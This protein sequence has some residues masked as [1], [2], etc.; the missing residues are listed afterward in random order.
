M[1]EPKKSKG[2]I[3]LILLLLLLLGV[4]GYFGVQYY[5]K[6]VKE[7]ETPQK[8][9]EQKEV[10]EDLSDAQVSYVLSKINFYDGMLPYGNF[11]ENTLNN[12]LALRFVDSVRDVEYVDFTKGTSLSKV[13]E[14]LKRYFGPKVHFNSEE[15]TCQDANNCFYYNQEEKKYTKLNVATYPYKTKNVYVSGK[16]E[17]T[18]KK[19]IVQ[20]RQLY[21]IDTQNGSSPMQFYNQVE[22]AINNQAPLFDLLAM[23][24]NEATNE[25][26]YDNTFNQAYQANL[27]NIPIVTYSFAYQSGGY[28]LEKVEK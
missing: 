10:F 12:E 5:F 27:G 13:E 7:K 19:I 17:V 28:Y 14:I 20:V 22:S 21:Y 11:D 2:K 26:H 23:Y 9:S 16:R 4:G 8:E 15:S 1:Y 25:V 6:E 18:T 3:V 24:G